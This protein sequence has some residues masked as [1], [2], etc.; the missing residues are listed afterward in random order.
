[1]ERRMESI[2]C[3]PLKID[4]FPPMKS[5][6]SSLIKS[7]SNDSLVKI[8]KICVDGGPLVERNGFSQKCFEFIIVLCVCFA[9]RFVDGGSKGLQWENFKAYGFVSA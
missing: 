5:S 2:V 4:F 8:L 7:P 3:E 9:M 1:M 6:S